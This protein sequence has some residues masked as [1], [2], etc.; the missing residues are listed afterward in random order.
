MSNVTEHIHSYL[1]PLAQEGKFCGAI[2]ASHNGSILY[3]NGFGKANFELAVENTT[4]T[5]FRIG[6][7]TKTFTAVSVLQLVQKGK[8]N[9]DD[10]VSKYFPN[11]KDGDKITVHHL[12]TH[13]SGIP[14][15]TDDPHMLEWSAQPSSPEKLIERFSQNDLEF[16]PGEQYKYS[17]SGYVLLGSILEQI[18]GQSYE[19]YLK[20]HIFEPLGMKDSGLDTPGCI[21]DFR[22]SGYHLSENGS[23][24]NAPFFDP[25]NAYSAGAIISTIEDM[26]IWDQTLHTEKLLKKS[27]I[28]QMFTPVKGEH[29]YMYGYG[30]IIQDTPFGK[31][32]AHSGGIP[33]FSSVLIRFLDNGVCVHVLSNILQDVS[34]IGKKIAEIIHQQN[35][36]K[37]FS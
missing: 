31:L 19:L 6:S 23:L 12:L 8:L 22:A 7:I 17:N 34:E 30:W 9:L 4:K 18:S 28:D 14:N 10:P 32:V 11:Q 25:S 36:A 16:P 35:P 21:L 26:H 1:E 5:K 27:F 33:G 13:T 2:L 24:L 15:Y 29:D 3:S 20:E 37:S